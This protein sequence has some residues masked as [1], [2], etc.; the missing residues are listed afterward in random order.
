MYVKENV[1][2]EMIYIYI[3]HDVKIEIISFFRADK[4]GQVRIVARKIDNF[5]NECANPKLGPLTPYGIIGL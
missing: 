4:F 2:R 3:V 5:E 1:P